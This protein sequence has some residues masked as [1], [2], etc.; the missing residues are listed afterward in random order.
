MG[1]LTQN[2]RKRSLSQS[3]NQSQQ[4]I[5]MAET[6]DAMIVEV[7]AARKRVE[8]LYGFHCCYDAVFIW[9]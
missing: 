2:V 6:M 4:L 9:L 8:F 7:M 5:V 1:S 3:V